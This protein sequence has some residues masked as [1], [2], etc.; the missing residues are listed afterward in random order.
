MRPRLEVRIAGVRLAVRLPEGPVRAVLAQAW[1]PFASS[2]PPDAELEVEVLDAPGLD[3]P[4]FPEIVGDA[5]GVR[6]RG[7]DFE[8]ELGP[9]RAR[10]VQRVSRYPVELLAKLLLAQV[11]A[12]GGG[13]LLHGVGVSNGER[14]A[15]FVAHSGG[16]KSTLGGLCASA[17]LALL[18]DELVAVRPHGAGLLA[19]GTPWNTGTPHAAPLAALGT[20]GFA[21][22]PALDPQAPADV[23]RQLLPN[24]LLPEPSPDARARLFRSA[25]EALQR[26]RCVRFRF[27]PTAEAAETL[28]AH[29]RLW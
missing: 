23:L 18:S 11:L 14:A 4:Q 19:C 25:G 27:P 22:A 8:A 9:G 12:R 3:A 5:S 21:D 1:A 24:A 17:G 15:V 26:T 13:L 29:L 16:G 20:L 2:G 28:R 10:V 6:V 7:E